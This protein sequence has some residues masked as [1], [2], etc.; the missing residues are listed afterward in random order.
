MVNS[1]TTT[2]MSISPIDY[3]DINSIS[4]LTHALIAHMAYVN[5]IY[6]DTKSVQVN[7]IR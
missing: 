1:T 6:T 2:T 7:A 4:F 5:T 3:T